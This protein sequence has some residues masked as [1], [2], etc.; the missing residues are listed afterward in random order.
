VSP[1]G[2]DTLSVDKQS[3]KHAAVLSL[4]KPIS[5][6]SPQRRK[7]SLSLLILCAFFVFGGAAVSLGIY[8]NVYHHSPRGNLAPT[9]FQHTPTPL[10]TPTP[11]STKDATSNP[12]HYPKI[13]DFYNGTAQDL[14]TNTTWHISL[15]QVQQNSGNIQGKFN[16][17]HITGSFSGVLDTSH[18]IFFTVTGSPDQ[19]S[20]FFE[21][22][23]RSDN[24]LVGNYCS[25]DAQGQCNGDYGLWSLSPGQ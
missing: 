11:L 7:L 10:N 14:L 17:M 21:G 9:P 25:I 15:T 1:M 2:T 4:S 19:P 16:G 23:V 22:A 20:Y 24:N 13:V 5:R 3:G 6:V 8:M 18:H 12:V